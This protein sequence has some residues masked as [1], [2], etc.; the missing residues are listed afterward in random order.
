MQ[1]ITRTV[2]EYFD[3]VYKMHNEV[4]ID[5]QQAQELLFQIDA[6]VLKGYNLPPCAERELLDYFGGQQCPVPFTFKE[7]FPRSFK[8][9]IPLWMY[10][11]PEFK[12]C[13]ARNFLNKIPKIKDPLLIEALKE[14]E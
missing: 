6:T 13:T 8:P 7:Y 2:K 14:I 12:K 10:L 1:T 5:D 9:A 3:Y 4:F 11:S